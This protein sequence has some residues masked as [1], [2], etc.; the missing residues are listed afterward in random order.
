MALDAS[1]AFRVSLGRRQV[2]ATLL[3]REVHAAVEGLEAGSE[4]GKFGIPSSNRQVAPR[5]SD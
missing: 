4:D 5:E 3:L 2:N 1:L